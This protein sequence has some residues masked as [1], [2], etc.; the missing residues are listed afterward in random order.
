MFKLFIEKYKPTVLY[1]WFLR[2]FQ[3]PNSWYNARSNYVKTAAVMSVCGYVLGLGDRH[4]E[5]ILM[6]SSN[7]DCIHVDFNC[8]FI[9]QLEN[10]TTHENLIIPLEN[11]KNLQNLRIP[12]ENHANH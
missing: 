2:T 7:G 4:C 3:E 10:H 11:Y 8:L 5:N 1:E 6:A 9:I 12:I